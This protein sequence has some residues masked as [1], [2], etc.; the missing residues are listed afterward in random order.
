MKEISRL[1]LFGWYFDR[2]LLKIEEFV[3]IYGILL[4]SFLMVGNVVSRL[5]LNFAWTFTP[6]I[7]QTL[8]V[9]ITFLGLGYCTR[10]ARHIR[11]TAL[12]DILPRVPKKVLMIFVS[13]V[14]GGLMVV[15]AYWSYGYTVKAFN[16]ESMTPVLRIPRYL[17]LMWVPLG[18]FICGVEYFMTVYKNLRESEVYVSI[19]MTDEYTEEEIGTAISGEGLHGQESDRCDHQSHF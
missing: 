2:G 4:L 18:L 13:L 11:M 5:F 10:K 15:L 7:A 16:S 6:E 8:M 14:T 19:E 1:Q 3:L 17:I 12:S 9:L